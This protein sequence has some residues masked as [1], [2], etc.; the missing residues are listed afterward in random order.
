MHKLSNPVTEIIGHTKA[1]PV[2]YRL[3]AV[4]SAE[5]HNR[6]TIEAISPQLGAHRCLESIGRNVLP[7]DGL[8]RLHAD[9]EVCQPGRYRVDE[10]ADR[11]VAAGVRVFVEKHPL[12]NLFSP[13]R[14]YDIRR[15]SVCPGQGDECESLST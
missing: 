4:R 1:G 10:R 11:P 15:M 2:T 9:I 14:R 7:S 5:H 3:S 8:R 13:V 6:R 12:R